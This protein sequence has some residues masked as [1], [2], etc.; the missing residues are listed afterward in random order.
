MPTVE[1]GLHGAVNVSGDS[2]QEMVGFEVSINGRFWV[3][4]EG[5]LLKRGGRHKMTL[6][7]AGG[8]AEH[9]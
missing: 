6:C 1:H 9:M 3:S 4:T 5:V 7:G 8:P 2:R